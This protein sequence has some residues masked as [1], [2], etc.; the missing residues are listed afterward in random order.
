M[1]IS[2]AR[3]TLSTLN[4]LAVVVT[5]ATDVYLRFLHVRDGANASQ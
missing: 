5:A 4:M 3:M 1:S 2:I